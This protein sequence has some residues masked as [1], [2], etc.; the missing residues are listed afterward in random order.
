M[1]PDAQTENDTQGAGDVKKRLRLVVEYDGTDFAGFQWQANERSVQGEIET[2]IKKLSGGQPV[3]IHGAG[4]TD[5]GVH[6][7]GQVVHFDPQWTVPVH[8]I[9]VA[10]NGLLPRDVTVRS[11]DE[12]GPDFHARFSATSRTYRYVI[13]NRPA[14]SALLARY[15]LYIREP[16]DIAAMQSASAELVGVRD[17][18]S[19][20]QP[21]VPGKSTM[22]EVS[23]LSVRSYK[24]GVF[25]TVRGNAFLRQ[26]VRCLV[27][28]LLRV[29]QS[30]LDRTGV[31]DVREAHSRAACPW[32]APARG[33]YL[34]RVG[35]DG[36]RVHAPRRTDE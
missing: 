11:A 29:G 13:L 8:R 5:A 33:L 18:A 7:S 16:L 20:G 3:R 17:F 10:L 32:L 22:R 26:M 24:D 35:Y 36:M 1:N 14:P 34:V 23:F 15:S 6:A 31:Q 30:K 19:F 12:V 28:T 9:A 25:L 21:D 4:R 27:G 2:A